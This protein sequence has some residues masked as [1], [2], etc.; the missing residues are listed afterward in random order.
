MLSILG[1]VMVL[2]FLYLI[3]TKRV[4]PFIGLII[5]PLIFG[6]IGGFGSQL[7]NLIMEGL[8]NTAP[9]ALLI[10]FAILYFAIMIDT[11]LFDPLKSRIVKL[12]KGDPLKV[13]VGS[14]ILAGIVGFDGDGSS[15]IMICLSAFL[16][17]YLKLGINPLILASITA[18]QIG[19][20]TLVP[21]GGPVGRVASV[22]NI[23]PTTLFISVLPGMIV[24]SIY[25]VF[26][27]YIIGKRERARLGIQEININKEVKVELS[28][29]VEGLNLKRPKLIWANLLLSII[30][31]IALI[32]GWL[33]S[34][35]LFIVGTAIAL[36]MNYP[37]LQI[38][39]KCI[40]SHAPNALNVTSII[41]AAGVFAGIL[42]G[43]GMSE[44]M[45]QSLISIIPSAFGPV[46]GLIVAIFGPAVIFLIG[47]DAYYFG[48]IPIIAET[49]ASYGINSMEIAIASLYGSPFG[50]IGPL[51]GAMYLLTETARV[52]IVKVQKYS[53]KWLL[54]V[55]AIFIIV[56]ISLGHI[57]I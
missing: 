29:T 3:L 49:A 56:G 57:S 11:G 52:N 23:D 10:L 15:T 37:S 32:L 16:P 47:P 8:T 41:L 27:A 5:I 24:G 22:L 9:T 40:S 2:T 13:I 4:S 35:V 18:M 38:Q 36:L 1:F 25:V 17:I 55:L 28:A 7:G 19:I 50:F 42:K 33:P 20:T 26:V 21:W 34:V 44:A 46:L 12:A 51:V 14:A 39:A 45:A 6:V 30:I 48:I 31:T 53:V 43:T 54:G